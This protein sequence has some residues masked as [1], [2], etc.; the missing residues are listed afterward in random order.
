VVARAYGHDAREPQPLDKGSLGDGCRLCEDFPL[1]L[2]EKADALRHGRFWSV[3]R[4]F[5]CGKNGKRG[6]GTTYSSPARGIHSETVHSPG[7]GKVSSGR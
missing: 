2:F 4:F 1:L 7:C 6:R 3:R 5:P